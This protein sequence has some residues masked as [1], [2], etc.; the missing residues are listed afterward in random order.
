MCI[1]L[2]F[3]LT[4]LAQSIN[5]SDFSVLGVS[6]DTL[7]SN[8]YL[9]RIH[10]NAASNSFVNYPYVMAVL[11]CNG[12]TVATGGLIFF[13]QSGQTSADYPVTISGSLDCEPLTLVFV[14]GDDSL[15]NH[16]C[17]LTFGTSNGLSNEFQKIDEFS[18]FPNPSINH[19]NIQSN[20]G[21]IGA[22]F[23]VYDETGRLILT[24]KL[25][26]ESTLVDMSNFSKGMYFFIVGDDI[27]QTFKVIKE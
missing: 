5:C 24:R 27:R 2:K 4:L 20:I 18:V 10:S 12:D 11:D 6:P 8:G 17:M 15:N 3:S 14:Y 13:G 26:S 23:Y 9:V 16:T 21:Q 25:I 7:N 19:V 22:S 1:L